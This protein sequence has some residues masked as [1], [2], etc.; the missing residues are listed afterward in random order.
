MT[1]APMLPQ[2]SISSA[3]R[4]DRA[5]LLGALAIVT[6]LA[7]S[8]LLRMGDATS[9]A[10]ACHRAMAMPSGRS[11]SGADLLDAAVMWGAMMLAMMLP[12]VTPWLVA[13]VEAARRRSAPALREAGAFLLGYGSVW[14]TYAVG[15]AAAQLLL[16]HRALLSHEWATTSPVLAAASLGVAGIYQWTPLRDSCMAHCRSPFGFFLTSWREGAWGS[17]AMGARH[18]VQCLGC[19][20]ALMAL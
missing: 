6:G 11:W 2:A 3:A 9:S 1:G 10:A 17:A 15:A 4:R 14:L 16:Q 20:W 5:I 7:W 19:C 8:H 12:V 18:G 13:L